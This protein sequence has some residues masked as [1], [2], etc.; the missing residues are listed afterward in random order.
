MQALAPE[1][2]D[3]EFAPSTSSR[4][5]VGISGPRIINVGVP[6]PGSRRLMWRRAWR[7]KVRAA[8]EGGVV[9]GHQDAGGGGWGGVREGQGEGGGWCGGPT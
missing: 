3:G 9:E 8:K 5:G 2:P 7:D 4:G 1:D 6:G